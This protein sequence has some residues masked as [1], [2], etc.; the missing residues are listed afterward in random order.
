M[1]IP[2]LFREIGVSGFFDILLM[3]LLIYSLLAWLK[4]TRRAVR[5]LTG[6]LIVGIVYLLA[7]QFDMRLTVA[8]L[9]GFFAVFLVALVVIFQ[10]ELRYFFEQIAHWSLHRRLPARAGA[11]H[12]LQDVDMLVRT[13]FDLG[14]RRVGALVVLRGK[15]ILVRHLEGGEDLGGKVGEAVLKSLFDPHSIGHDGAVIIEGN[16]IVR[17]GCVLPLSRNLRPSARTGTRH[18]AALGLSE[19][20]DA[21]CLVVSEERGTVSIARHGKLREVRDADGLRGIVERFLAETAPVQPEGWG[22]LLT[23]NTKEKVVALGLALGLWF[24]LVHESRIVYA[25]FRV[26]VRFAQVQSGP[27]IARVEPE[28]LEVTF[29]APRK[30]LYFVSAA[31]IQVALSTWELAPG[32][33]HIAITASNLSFPSDLV[34]ENV[35]PRDV[36]VEVVGVATP[37]KQ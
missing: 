24:V 11:A 16:T 21:L 12:A 18:A 25:T 22:R 10:E 3:A 29:S 37:E 20:S 5:A 31:N 36:V 14:R 30:S 27:T 9:Q 17:F 32:R 26:P 13:L 8:V 4:R 34:L 23:A 19:L 1:Q 15:D 6:I 7:Q 28:T 33:T 2:A 35:K